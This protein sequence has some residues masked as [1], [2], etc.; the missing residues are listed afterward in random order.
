MQSGGKGDLPVNYYQVCIAPFL[1]GS[2]DFVA[3]TRDR[4]REKTNM[5]PPMC[6]DARSGDKKKKD[7]VLVIV[8]TGVALSSYSS[9]IRRRHS[10]SILALEDTH[11]HS[12]WQLRR[13]NT[14][15][16]KILNSIPLIPHLNTILRTPT[17]TPRA[18]VLLMRGV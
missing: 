1:C 4:V 18:A 14:D 7:K 15:S 12:N 8:C 5:V 10:D 11:D 6:C 3:G 17:A 9:T 16:R 2:L 13:I